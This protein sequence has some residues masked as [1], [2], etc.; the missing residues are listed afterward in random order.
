VIF[1]GVLIG[2]NDALARLLVAKIPHLLVP[3]PTRMDQDTDR[4][5]ASYRSSIRR[6]RGWTDRPVSG[7]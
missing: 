4:D 1:R 3:D 5:L 2:T 7:S 6:E